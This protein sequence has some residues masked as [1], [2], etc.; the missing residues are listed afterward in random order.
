MED[1]KRYLAERA[2]QAFGDVEMVS[3]RTL[4]PF[5]VAG[6]EAAQNLLTKAIRALDAGDADRAARFVDHAARLPFDEHE[7]RAPAGMEA[8]MRLFMAVTDAMETSAEDDS[9]WLD[10]ALQLLTTWDEWA[11][12]EI[13]DIL[14]DILHDYEL[15]PRERARIREALRGAPEHQGLMDQD[16]PADQL[17]E[18]VLGLLVQ[19]REYQRVLASLPN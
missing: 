18:R 16:L 6:Q 7:R 3:G 4:R 11:Q 19:Y 13:C 10:A 12:G 5:S 17:A 9:R 2:D 14:A 8:H 15:L 1:L